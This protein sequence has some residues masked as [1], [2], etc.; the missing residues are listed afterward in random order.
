MK[1]TFGPGH[2]PPG[3]RRRVVFRSRSSQRSLHERGPDR[4]PFGPQVSAERS[5]RAMCDGWNVTQVHRP[6]RGRHTPE[7][8]I[9]RVS[10]APVFPGLDDGAHLQANSPPSMAGIFTSQNLSCDNSLLQSRSPP[11][12]AS[13]DR[14]WRW[15][16]CY[17][18]R[19]FCPIRG[20]CD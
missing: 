16:E 18:R 9:R 12:D 15:P 8:S 7:V 13:A 6:L 14:S 4:V 17:R 20:I 19:R 2:G 1:I 11:R 5:H 3:H 10:W